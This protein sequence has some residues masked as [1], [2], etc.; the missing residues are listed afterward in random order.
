M[1]LLT[2]AH[3]LG[4]PLGVPIAGDDAKAVKLASSLIKQVGFGPVLIGNLAK[5]R[6]LV[7][8]TPFGG[9]HTPAE[10]GKIAAR[11]S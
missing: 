2:E 1:A 8:G 6:Y 3:R 4:E 5:G 7:P 9:L 10:L 11:L